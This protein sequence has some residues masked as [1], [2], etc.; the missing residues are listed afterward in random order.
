MKKLFE[1]I[2]LWVCVCFAEFEL[3]GSSTNE[4]PAMGIFD[5]LHAPA[6]SRNCLNLFVGLCVFWSI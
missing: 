5:R 1:R 6:G 2:S 4:D 3:P